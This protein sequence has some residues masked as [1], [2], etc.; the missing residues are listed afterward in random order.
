MRLGVGGTLLL[1]AGGIFAYQTSGYDLEGVVAQNLY[2][3]SPKEFV[4]VRAIAARMVRADEPRD[5]APAYPTPEELG[6][7][8]QIDVFVAR[9]DD[10]NR[11]DLRRLLHLTEHALP[12]C[13][14][15]ARRFTRL[16]GDEQDRVLASMETSSVGLLRGAFNALKALCV[17]AFFAHPLTWGAIGYDGPLVGRPAAG[18]VETARLAREHTR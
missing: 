18:W 15:F 6:V 10:A 14:G 12:F 1:G 7:A 11:R 2:A 13:A 8:S 17:M 5:G 4:I 9:L 3:L 16:S